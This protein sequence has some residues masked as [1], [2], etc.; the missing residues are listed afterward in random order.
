[1]NDLK[2]LENITRQ[3]NLLIVDD[4]EIVRSFFVEVLNPYFCNVF[5]GS[6]GAKGIEIF[7]NEKID[8]IISDQKMPFMTG[9]DM[10]KEIRKRDR[11]VPVILIT[12]F[13]DT[14]ILLEA[15]NASVNQFL[16][17]PV[18]IDALYRAVHSCLV[19]VIT[20]RQK[21]LEQEAEI[22]KYREHYFQ[23][24]QRLTL[25]KQQVLIRDELYM[26]KMTPLSNRNH[27]NYSE[28][29]IGA[30]YQPFD[31]LSGDFYSIR[32]INP[33][34]ALIFLADAMGKGLSAFVSSSII[35]A[36]L[37]HSVDRA[38]ERSDFNFQR[39][40]KDFV[41]YASRQFT[42]DEALCVLFVLLDIKAEVCSIANCGMPPLL[43]ETDSGE[44]I[45]ISSEGLPITRTFKECQIK[46]YP[47]ARINRMLIMTDGGYEPDREE[48]LIDDFR[49][50]YFIGAFYKRLAKREYSIEDDRTFIF[51][52]RL[53]RI[54]SQKETFAINSNRDKING[55]LD[56]IE[57]MLLNRGIP[58]QRVAEAITAL[59]E[60]LLNA[61]EHGILG[62][63]RVLKNNLL[64]RDTYD[65]FIKSK[66]DADRKISV[67]M[68]EFIE[69]DM[70]YLAFSIG[71]QGDGFDTS[72]YRDSAS[73]SDML[74]YRGIKIT[75]H[76][77][78]E[79]FYN[80]KGNEVFLI[81]KT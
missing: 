50:S 11:A 21:A 41:D 14:E 71:D 53:N 42:R 62:M 32:R 25:M 1:M 8:L 15:I 18:R 73:E 28:W 69:N 27:F 68:E 49:S 35:T 31:T 63:G 76:M 29:L 79:I 2:E 36:F 5:Q 4:E 72:I 45:K 60:M 9:L 54:S 80:E 43:V 17:K 70:T 65:D 56:E 39:L 12:A 22:L 26:K 38:I 7:N 40:L 37:N 44:V 48:M 16:V 19:N 24:Q 46:T 51:I 59:S 66:E 78:D 81:K 6:D 47:L 67:T 58:E 10:V 52:R 20:Q 23:M 64:K 55:F 74:N 34:T 30:N 77:V 33:D 13:T 3:L 75:T 61:Y 57:A